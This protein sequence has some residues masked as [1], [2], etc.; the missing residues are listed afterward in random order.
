MNKRLVILLSTICI[1]Y[2]SCSK[3]KLPGPQNIDLGKVT[4]TL[5]SGNNQR[6]TIG[7]PLKKTITIKVTQN[8]LP[9]AGYSVQFQGSGCDDTVSAVTQYGGT[10]GYTWYLS[11]QI[12]QQTL[13][14]YALNSQNQKVDSVTAVATALATGPGWHFSACTFQDAQ[15]IIS[16]AKLSTGRLFLTYWA[17]KYYLR[18]S[19]DN[20]VTWNALK[21]LGNTHM[22]GYVMSTPQDELFV[23]TLGEA[24]LYSKDVGQT[25]STLAITPFD[26][27]LISTAICTPSGKLL[28]TSGN[29]PLS[30]SN[31]RGKTWTTVPL[32]AFTSPNPASGVSQLTSAA[33]DRAGNLYV[34]ET[35]SQTIFKSADMGKTWNPVKP[36]ESD[37]A[38]YID[39]N[40]WFY[41]SLVGFEGGIYISKD[42]GT[43]YNQ[44]IGSSFQGFGNMS[45]QSD[46]NF[47]CQDAHGFYSSA[48]LGDPFKEIFVFKAEDTPPYIVAKNNNI[49]MRGTAN[50]VAQYYTK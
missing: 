24:A 18:Y 22:I 50:A 32:T 1:L 10:T 23:F 34:E 8:G 35:Q 26:P 33:E 43:T 49:I 27:R 14:I 36:G 46:G 25:W 44:M 11:S 39:N 40:N 48:G 3:S 15:P 13:K 6:D 30:I 37:G 42:E 29:V 47:Y 38:F 16:F 20:G 31:D 45:V 21:T 9:L 5:D 4:I 41:K 2:F 7:R 17:G 28:V 12:G 19:D